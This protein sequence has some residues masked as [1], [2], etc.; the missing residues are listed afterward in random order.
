MPKRRL[1]AKTADR[2]DLYQ[3]SVQSPDYDVRFLA[4]YYRKLT[5]APLRHLREDFCGTAALACA[6]VRL[7]RENRALGVDLDGPTLDWGREHNLAALTENQRRR[8]LLKQADVRAVTTP[9]VELTV[10]LNFSYC[11]LKTRD[12]L[13]DYFK[14]VRRGLQPGGLFMMD[15]YGGSESQVEQE[16]ERDVDGFTYVWDQ[17]DFDP[18][19]YHGTCKIHFAFKDGTRMRDAFVYEWRLWTVPEVREVLLEAGFVDFHV[20]WEQTDHATNEGNGVYRRVRRGDADP[21]WI[22][23]L[24][25]RRP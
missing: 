22:A 12:E 2:H 23:Y 16:E 17:A 21:A 6:F 3:R 8:V 11:I 7:H 9:K 10:A 19:T 24:V 25:A 4:R 15:A 5:G 14:T 1:S 20:L 13:R 18:L